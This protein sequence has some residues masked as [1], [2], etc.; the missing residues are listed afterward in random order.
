MPRK[1]LLGCF[2]VPGYGGAST[3]AYRLFQD[4]QGQGLDAAFVNIIGQDDAE[5]LRALY[6]E[7]MGNPRALRN[8]HNLILERAA[9]HPS[10]AHA[11]LGKLIREL[12]PD[13]LIG[14]GYIA[15]LLLKAAAP[16][17]KII[18]ITTGCDQ[19]KS[20]IASGHA[21]TAGEILARIEKRNASGQ[22]H[23]P[24][25]IVNAAEEQAAACADLILVH[26]EMTR[27][28]F[29]Y[30]FPSQ[31]VKVLPETLWLA[32]WITQDA[33]EHRRFWKPF[34]ERD[35]DVVLA[36]SNWKRPE[37]N[38]KLARELILRHPEWNWHVLGDGVERAGSATY[39]GLVT[40][41]EALY[42][43]LGRARMLVSPSCF[44][45]APGV[46]F[47]AAV[48]GCN[49]IASKNCGN[50]QVCPPELLAADLRA[51]EFGER[52]RR[53]RMREYRHH[54]DVFLQSSARQTL[55]E[56]LDV[57]E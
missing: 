20:A 52:I 22:F 35:I 56:I 19:A 41:R 12:A 44:D 31:A 34:A 13:V 29:R 33:A 46:L 18:F 39:H 21:K 32:E 26:S 45:T 11:N 47:E 38:W 42:E 30:Y 17:K 57:L 7:T 6:G 25:V 54:L 48:M 9:Y 51:G 28:L 10:A 37:K 5:L 50:W 53:G 43:L 27:A 1:F 8:V 23:L 36:A 2:E 49:V 55:L 40:D 3:V 14:V 15:A 16:D 4:L 24:P